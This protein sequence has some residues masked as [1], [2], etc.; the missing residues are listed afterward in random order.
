L[1]G[2]VPT[3]TLSDP[4]GKKRARYAQNGRQGKTIWV[5]CAWKEKARNHA[6]DEPDDCDP[7]KARHSILLNEFNVGGALAQRVGFQRV[8]WLT[9]S[10]LCPAHLLPG[11]H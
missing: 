8:P 3:S 6:S 10:P 2:P 7:Y 4:R 9:S 11:F 5:V 1:V